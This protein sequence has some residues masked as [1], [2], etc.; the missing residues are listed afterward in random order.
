M[1]CGLRV[2]ARLVEMA[3]LK[4]TVNI[5]VFA[6]TRVHAR[7]R[8]RLV[9]TQLYAIK[10]KLYILPSPSPEHATKLLPSRTGAWVRE[11]VR[12]I[13]F[14]RPVRSPSQIESSLMATCGGLLGLVYRRIHPDFYGSGHV[15]GPVIR[16]TPSLV[17]LVPIVLI[18]THRLV[19]DGPRLWPPVEDCLDWSIVK[20]I[21]VSV[22]VA[23]S[24][25]Q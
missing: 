14:S 7:V 21:Q 17:P 10:I 12:S 20:S 11:R 8:V 1:Q 2:R 5:L 25:G 18:G 6:R 16:H 23:M 13:E 22:G 24:G 9:E 15:W 4:I 3:P 19:C